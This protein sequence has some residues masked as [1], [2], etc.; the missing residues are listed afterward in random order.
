MLTFF[1]RA[2][3]QSIFLPLAVLLLAGCQ[4][5]ASESGSSA[6]PA[7]SPSTPP[8]VAEN[9]QPVGPPGQAPVARQPGTAAPVAGAPIP[10]SLHLVSPGQAGRLRLGLREAQ[11]RALVPAAQLRPAPD[12]AGRQVI[13]LIDAGQPGAPATRLFLAASSG[14][15]PVLRR[16]LIT[17]PQYRT[18]EGI[19]VGSPFG[20]ARQNLGFTRLRDTPFGL[21][22]VSGQVRLAWLIDPGSLPAGA[23]QQMAPATI[24]AAAR[25]TGIVLY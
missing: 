23:D 8:F 19:G 4:G 25:I 20:A 13:E 1:F 24:P 16:I 14:G 17:D 21:A 9:G 6:A 5:P 12:S 18:A 15:E 7:A 11:L 3:P 2:R 22:A 10:D